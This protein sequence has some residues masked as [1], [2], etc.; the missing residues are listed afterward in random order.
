[1]METLLH[2]LRAMIQFPVIFWDRY[3]HP[4]KKEEKFLKEIP[5]TS[6]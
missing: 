1:M 4:Q 5:V 3:F 2:A 6:S